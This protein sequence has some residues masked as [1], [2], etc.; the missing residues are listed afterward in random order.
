MEEEPPAP[1]SPPPA[2]EDANVDLSD[3]IKDTPK[4][5]LGQ[6]LGGDLKTE[7]IPETSSALC[8]WLSYH[9]LDGNRWRSCKQCYRMLRGIADQLVEEKKPVLLSE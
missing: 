8:P 3:M 7:P 1:P 9:I 2:P 5:Q 6:E 4:D